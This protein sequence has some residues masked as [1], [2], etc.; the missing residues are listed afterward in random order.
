MYTCYFAKM[1]SIP[2]GKVPIAICRYAPSWY[3]GRILY[4]TSV[5]NT[6]YMELPIIS[7][8]EYNNT[9]RKIVLS[10][11]RLNN[12]SMILLSP[13]KIMFDSY[14][15]THDDKLFKY[16]YFTKVLKRLDPHR[17]HEA[18]GDDAVLLCYEKVTD[19]C[20]RHYVR[21]WMSENGINIV[22]LD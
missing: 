22:E 9:G 15:V 21:E 14:K 8:D 6:E 2:E 4:Q 10:D 7:S 20:H 11:K 16:E 5:W 19:V 12:Y 17:I 13:S 18:L 1:K 3:T